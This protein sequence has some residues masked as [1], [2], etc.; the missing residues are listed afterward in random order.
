[1]TTE[2]PCGPEAQS[3]IKRD[4]IVALSGVFAA[5]LLAWNDHR[6][7]SDITQRFA[8]AFQRSAD[9]QV[10]LCRRSVAP[11]S[12]VARPYLP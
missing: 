7:M 10:E 2:T 8:E 3:L 12:L 6:R 11:P 9:Y 4:R 5:F 1:M